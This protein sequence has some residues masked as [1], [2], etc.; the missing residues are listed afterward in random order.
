[1]FVSRIVER[2]GAFTER[3]IVIKPNPTG[4]LG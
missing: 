2:R 3:R 1:M 4:L